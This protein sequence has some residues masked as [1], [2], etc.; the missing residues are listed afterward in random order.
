MNVISYTAT[1]PAKLLNDPKRDSNNKYLTLHKFI[2]GVNA[3][4]DNGQV[5]SESV[6]RPSE[7]AFMLGWV[8]EHGKKSPHL[9]LRKTIV[10]QQQARGARTVIADSNL[11][12]YKDTKNPQYYLRYSFDGVF[13]NTGEYCDTNPDP[14]RWQKIKQD[15]G[16]DLRPWRTSGS[17]LLLC[18]QRNGGWSMGGTNVIDWAV[19]TVQILKRY[20]DRPIIIRSHPGDKGR[21]RDTTA[22]VTTLQRKGIK[23]IYVSPEKSELVHDLRNCWA[24]INHNSSPV[25]GA[26]I[27]GIPIFVTD[28]MNSQA[29][30]V[31]NTDLAKI[32][33]PD[34]PDRQNWIE[35]LSQF[36][37][38][39]QDISD[40]TAWR[41]M[42]QWA[43]KN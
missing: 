34:I 38:N 42:R 36:H 6:Y 35:R 11:F 31:A 4:G 1:L 24:V 16:L 39:F 14:A 26:A 18:L 21:G 43:I 28:P 27:E 7:V 17:H 10:E 25:V 22:I 41:H 9:M 33:N 15:L 5:V 23:K 20:T 37:W 32:E 30:D 8:H 2:Q 40:G 19:D 3:A 13:P 12:L 29:R